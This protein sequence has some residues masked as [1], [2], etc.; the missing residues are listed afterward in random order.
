MFIYRDEVYNAA[1]EDKGIAEI[2][3][4]KNRNGPIGMAKI[5][6]RGETASFHDITGG[7]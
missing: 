3:I 6:F 7:F 5:V 2:I 4:G 1:T